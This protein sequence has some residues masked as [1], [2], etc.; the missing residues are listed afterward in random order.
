MSVRRKYELPR[1]FILSLGELDTR[2]GQA[3]LITTIVE[4]DIPLDVVMVSRHTTHAD[5]IV[6]YAR[7]KKIATRVHILYEVEDYEFKSLFS[8]A[9]GMVYTPPEGGSIE[10]IIEGLKSGC[11]MVLSDTRINREVARGAAIYLESVRSD[12]IADALRALIYDASYRGEL[13]AQS[14]NEAKRFSE[15]GVA[16]ELASIYDS[17]E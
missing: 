14:Y 16:Q 15:E 12:D 9:M 10:P 2:H 8:L 4:R 5:Q 6:G 11:V 13:R 17:V 3:E 7:R 1:S